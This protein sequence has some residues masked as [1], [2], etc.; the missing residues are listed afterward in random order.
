M[1]KPIL[2]TGGAGYIGSHTVKELIKQKFEVV[3][4]DNLSSGHKWAVDKKAKLVVGDLLDTKKLENTFKKYKP[5]AVIH[6]AGLIEVG[7]SVENPQKYY[8]NNIVGTLSLLDAMIKTKIKNI[9]FSSSAAVYGNPVTIPIKENDIK[10]PTNPYGHTKKIIEDILN[11]YSVAYGISSVSLRYF[12][13]SG[14]DKEGKL[15]ES[16]SPETHLIPRILDSLIKEREIGIFGNTYKTKD[17]TCIRDYIHV[18][19]LALAHILAINFLKE[20]KGKFAFNLGSG[21]G[22]SVKEIIKS[23]EN[24]TDR[25]AKIAVKPKRKGDPAVLLADISLAKKKLRWSPRYSEI[26]YILETA[27]DWEQKKGEKNG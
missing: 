13:A 18:E 26:D 23:A 9:V 3:V 12:N 14:A 1:K 8:I 17:G 19:D 2:V 10:E 24:V 5:Q 15:G 21:K 22:F 11:D 27:W 4:Y 6:F 25:K 7:E 20:N 16:H